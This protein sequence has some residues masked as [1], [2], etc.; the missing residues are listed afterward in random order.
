MR[1][2]SIINRGRGP[3]LAG[4]RITVFDVVPFLEAGDSPTYIATALAL[5]TREVDFLIKYIEE[6][7]DEVMAENQKIEERIMRGNPPEVME[8]LAQ[9]RTHQ[10]IEARWREFEKKQ[11]REAN[12]E[13]NSR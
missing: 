12:G 11:A 9:S 7:R 1:P 10:L 5:S 8:K 4:T 6:H 13:G 3:E 2:L